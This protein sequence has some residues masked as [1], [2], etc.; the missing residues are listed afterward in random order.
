MNYFK[1]LLNKKK[2]LLGNISVQL[3]VYGEVSQELYIQEK[4]D[5]VKNMIQEIDHGMSQQLQEEKIQLLFLIPQ[6]VCKQHHLQQEL[7]QPDKPVLQSLKHLDLTIGPEQQLSTPLLLQI[8]IVYLEQQLKIKKEQLIGLIT[9]LLQV[10]QIMKL[11]S[12]KLM[13]SLLKQK[14]MSSE[15]PILVKMSFFS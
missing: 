6:E 14:Q 12:K 4:M 13:K 3:T 2:V 9:L 8:Q 1:K 5:C 7:N 11:V 10:K 15:L